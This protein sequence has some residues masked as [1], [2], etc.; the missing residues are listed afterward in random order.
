VQFGHRA[1]DVGLAVFGLISGPTAAVRP[2]QGMRRHR[3][4]VPAAVRDA[5][6]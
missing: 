1:A 5:P 4:R 3:S 6:R 2:G